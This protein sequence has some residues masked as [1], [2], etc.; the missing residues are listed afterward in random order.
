MRAVVLDAYGGPEHLAVAHV[1]EPAAP[2][3]NAVLISVTAA[4]VN[5]VDLQTRAGL[6][7]GH[8]RLQP[9]MI[10]GW[11]VAGSVVAVGDD[12]TAVRVGDRVV[13]MSAQMATGRGTYAE[14]VAL[15]ADITAPAPA[16]VPLTTAAGLPLAGLTA[17]Q[18]LDTLDLPQGATLLVTGA[19]G[20]VGGLAVQLARLRG[21]RVVAQ[22]RHT[23]DAEEALALGAHEVT[24]T[25]EPASGGPGVDG[26]LDTAGLPRAIG[27]VRDGGRV[28]SIVP[29]RRP[30][31]ERGITVTVSHVEQDGERLAELSALVDRG[32][33]RL[34]TAKEYGFGEAAEAHRALAEGGMRGKLLLVP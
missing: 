27:T 29:T 24:L 20:S 7:A 34:R 9:P 21:L 16:S 22:V 5:P 31:E 15:P 6:H 13:A 4:A 2:Q 28:V 1:P 23:A 11:D 25:V 19:V 10:L 33:L 12:V 17:Q 32:A 8:S 3:A 14:T 26:L 30:V 18:A